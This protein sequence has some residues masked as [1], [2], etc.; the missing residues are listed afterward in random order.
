MS[1]FFLLNV[2]INVKFV[3]A[4]ADVSVDPLA[5]LLGDYADL[6]GDEGTTILE[7]DCSIDEGHDLSSQVTLNEVEQGYEITDNYKTNP[8]RLSLTGEVTDSPVQYLSVITTGV[9]SLGNIFGEL[10]KSI[11]SWFILKEL[12]LSGTPFDIVTGLDLYKNM[13]IERLS[14]PKNSG[15]GRTLRFDAELVQVRR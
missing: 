13:V 15:I 7:L 3:E 1:L 6:L 2:P 4:G 14:V 8:Q 9:G 12:W 5:A 10:S 11:N